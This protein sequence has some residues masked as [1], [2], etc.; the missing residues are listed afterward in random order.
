MPLTSISVS[1]CPVLPKS[2]IRLSKLLNKKVTNVIKP[3][4]YMYQM[5]PSEYEIMKLLKRKRGLQT[6]YNC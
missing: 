3:N 1:F 6:K 5:C 4:M 2:V